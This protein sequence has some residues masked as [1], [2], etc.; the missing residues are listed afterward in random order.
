MSVG[1]RGRRGRLTMRWRIAA[2]VA[3]AV[4]G[5]T[6]G[7]TWAAYALDRSNSETKF[8]ALAESNVRADATQAAA[9]ARN[10]SRRHLQKVVI[11]IVRRRTGIGWRLEGDGVMGP[12]ETCTAD[13]YPALTAAVTPGIVSSDWVTLCNGGE[14]LGVATAPVRGVNLIEF[15]D[16]QPLRSQ[17]SHLRDVLVV[18]DLVGLVLAIVLGGV[19]GTKIGRPLQQAAAAARR[20]GSG[21]LSARVSSAGGSELA[22]LGHAFNDMAERLDVAMTELQVSHRQQRQFVADVSHELRT[23]LAAMLAAADGMSSDDPVIEDRAK[24]LL[25]GQTRRLTRLVD[26][27]LE[28]SHFDAG[29]AGLQVEQTPLDDLARDAA[30][31]VAPGEHVEITTTGDVVVEADPRRVHTI[32]RNLIGNAVEHGKPPVAITIDGSDS[33]VIM[34]VTDAGPGIDPQLGAEVFR[35]FVRA[36]RARGRRGGTVGSNGLGLAIADENARLHGGSLGLCAADPTAVVLRL[37]RHHG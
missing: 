25:V 20:L 7:L 26:D 19:V 10:T 31:T 9:A 4:I 2:T 34:T 14:W 32:L 36:D 22:D 17:L 24:V 13:N 29:Q 23:P 18:V 5:T 8:I 1:V 6:V 11:D 15:Y 28:I 27:L 16:Y 35:R 12:G 30:T 3:V 37:P 21:D 33:E